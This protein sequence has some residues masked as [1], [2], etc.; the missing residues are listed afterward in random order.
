[1]CI[2]LWNSRT[3]ATPVVA[4][5]CLK[6]INPL[7]KTSLKLKC[8]YFVPWSFC[9]NTSSHHTETGV[10][11]PHTLLFRQMIS[12]HPPL[13]PQGRT[14]IHT[15]THTLTH[16]FQGC[17]ERKEKQRENGLRNKWR[18]KKN[19][20]RWLRVFV[21]HYAN[22]TIFT[23]KSSHYFFFFSL[24]CNSFFFVWSE[25]WIIWITGNWSSHKWCLAPSL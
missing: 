20:S 15:H 12:A 18:Y 22:I 11:T 17:D 8:R 13:L 14:H 1:M 16:A 9:W 25:D 2:I 23:F 3:V 4:K 6:S 21:G 19:R 24:L 5:L 7:V 10:Q